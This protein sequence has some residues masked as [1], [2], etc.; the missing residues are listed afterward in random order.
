MSTGTVPSSRGGPRARP[1]GATALR[2]SRHPRHLLGSTLRAT[3]VLARTG[4]EVVVLGKVE[5]GPQGRA[6]G[7]P[8]RTSPSA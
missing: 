1:P 5:E 4:F 2:G 3:R 7:P 6:E 8:P